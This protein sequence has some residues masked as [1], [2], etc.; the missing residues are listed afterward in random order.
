MKRT[1]TV[2]TSSQAD[3]T[4][5]N[6]TGARR[7]PYCSGKYAWNGSSKDYIGRSLNVSD[8]ILCVYV[9]RRSDRYG[10]YAKLMCIT[11]A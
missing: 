8:E 7:F 5:K 3:R 11:S 9:Q 6:T 1:I 10:A 4:L 2:T